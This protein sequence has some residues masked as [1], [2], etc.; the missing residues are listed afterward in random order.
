MSRKVAQKW[1]PLLW[2]EKSAMKYYTTKVEKL[3][4]R[5]QPIAVIS[6]DFRSNDRRHSERIKSKAQLWNIPWR[7]YQQV[8]RE[9]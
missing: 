2:T 5:F 1:K 3:Q 6:E 8:R 9:S 7:P 4:R